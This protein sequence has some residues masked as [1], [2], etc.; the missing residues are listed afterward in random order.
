MDLGD[1]NRPQKLGDKF[2]ELYCNEW[3]DA[4]EDLTSH[5]MS[6]KEATQLLLELMKV[7]N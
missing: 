5:K 6:D 3:I 7:I 2:A 4:H 1:P